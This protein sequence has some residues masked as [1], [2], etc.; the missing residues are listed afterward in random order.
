MNGKITDLYQHT[1]EGII[2]CPQILHNDKLG[3]MNGLTK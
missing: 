3:Q 1:L 2:I